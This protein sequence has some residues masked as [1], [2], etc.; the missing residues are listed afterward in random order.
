MTLQR[1]NGMQ[2]DGIRGYMQNGQNNAKAICCVDVVVCK[3]SKLTE[4]NAVTQECQG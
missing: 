4:V 2:D 1:N 3:I